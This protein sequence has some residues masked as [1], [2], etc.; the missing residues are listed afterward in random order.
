MKDRK[1]ASKEQ[2]ARPLILGL[3]SFIPLALLCFEIC[4]LDKS[5][6]IPAVLLAGP[7]LSMIGV[8]LSIIT[9]RSRKLYPALWIS[10]LVVCILGFI[11]SVS[12]IVLIVLFLMA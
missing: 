11:M 3:F 8:I 5:P 1:P 10:G 9:G 6:F 4:V 12:L 7:I 2:V